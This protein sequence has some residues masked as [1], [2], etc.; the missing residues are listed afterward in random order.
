MASTTLEDQLQRKLERSHA[1][2]EAKAKE[3][4]LLKHEDEVRMIEQKKFEKEMEREDMKIAD[5]VANFTS[6]ELENHANIFL[7]T[8]ES[9]VEGRKLRAEKLVIGEKKAKLAKVPN[10]FRD[11]RCNGCNKT[12]TVAPGTKKKKKKKKN[13]K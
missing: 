4:R 1:K 3:A 13:Q 11:W 10:P 2:K 5:D 12:N 6:A 9:L 7:S 8:Y